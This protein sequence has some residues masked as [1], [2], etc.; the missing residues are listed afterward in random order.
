MKSLKNKL[1]FEIIIR[2]HLGT[3][4]FSSISGGPEWAIINDITPKIVAAIW[5]MLNDEISKN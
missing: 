4:R 3:N 2:S 1:K 5:R